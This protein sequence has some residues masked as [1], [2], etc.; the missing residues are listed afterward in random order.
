MAHALDSCRLFHV[1]DW[2][3]PMKLCRIK[4]FS[5]LLPVINLHRLSA[6][7]RFDKPSRQFRLRWWLLAFA[8]LLV[9]PVFAAGVDCGRPRDPVAQMICAH[10][11]IL[12]LDSQLSSAYAEALAR[13]PSHANDLKQDEV[14]WL[15]ERNREMWWLLASKRQFPLV[16][17]DLE[18]E[19]AHVYQLRIAFLRDIDNP[20]ATRGMPIA[21]SL[22]KAAAT[23]PARAT[24]PLQ[25][26]EATGTVVLLKGQYAADPERAIAEMAAPPDAA[27]RSALGGFGHLYEF[28][29]AYFPSMGFGGAF[30]VEG[31]AYC[32]YWVVF[33][34]RGDA[35]VP[36]SGAG[37]GLLDGCM[38][39]GGLTGYLALLDGYPVALQ[40]TNDPS[41]PN[42]T[43]FQWRRW[44]GGNKWGPARRIRFRY[45]YRLKL[46]SLDS[47]FCAGTSPVCAASA[48][49]SVALST[50][51]HYMR[52][53]F[54]LA[55]PAD[56][57]G[58][59]R[60]RFRHLLRLAPH[61][62]EWGYCWYPVW[63]SARSG[64][65]LA[66]GGITQSHI[67]CHP[68]GNSLDVAF[69]ETRDHGTQWRH[70]DRI[71]DIVR[72]NLLFAAPIPPSNRRY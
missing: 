22:L 24:D 7:A 37:G 6:L 40:V 14:N 34:K 9:R 65:K 49:A 60:A 44:L 16:P 39:D 58:A 17:S 42:L 57:T 19:L 36:V 52:N 47:D 61:R 30:N 29:V 43:D 1:A 38:R 64:G 21:Q 56:E 5:V 63:F 55:N 59:Q 8:A 18:T 72:K 54:T 25:A 27:L 53:P 10:P 12:A 46:S 48:S 66:I 67:G 20:D 11:K 62:K 51:R 31:S 28:T 71:I 69:W 2:N 68:A 26:L 3:K 33:E 50:A 15:G 13:D 32:Q 41:F 4:T 45:A 35:T 23:L 70:A